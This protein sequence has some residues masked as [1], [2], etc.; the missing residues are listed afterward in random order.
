M[1]IFNGYIADADVTALFEAAG[2][3][4]IPRL[5]RHLNS[6]IVSLAVSLGT[7]IVAPRYGAYLEHL[8]LTPNALYKPGDGVAMAAILPIRSSQGR[9]TKS[10]IMSW[11]P[12][13]DG[14]LGDSTDQ[15]GWHCKLKFC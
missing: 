4:L 7:P 14:E 5:G 9:E 11:A 6:G 8:G 13:R 1:Q 3:V 2:A 12:C 15:K 10:C